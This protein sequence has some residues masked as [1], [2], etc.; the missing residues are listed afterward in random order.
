MFVMVQLE[1]RHLLLGSHSTVLVIMTVESWKNLA[2]FDPQRQVSD[3][4]PKQLMVLTPLP[5]PE[6]LTIAMDPYLTP[7][8]AA[9]RQPNALDLIFGSTQNHLT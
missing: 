6:Q 8:Y 9:E 7:S 4:T 3:R 2:A 1:S 5:A